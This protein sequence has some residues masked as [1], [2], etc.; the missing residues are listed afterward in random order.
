[1]KITGFDHYNIRVPRAF[2]EPLCR[3]YVEA[4]N[5]QVGPRPAF[6][7]TGYWLYAGDRPLLHLTGFESQST[8]DI[9][10]RSTGWFSHIAF[11]CED[12]TATAARLGKLGIEY[13]MDAVPELGQTQ[14]FFTDPAG[15]GVELNFAERMTDDAR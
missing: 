1:M 10:T 8:D 11:G 7:S 15:I 4:L 12:L 6:R 14:L 3:F 9:E 13:E 5:L 2:L